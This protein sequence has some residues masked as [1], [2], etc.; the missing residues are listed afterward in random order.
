[1][2]SCFIT[3]QENIVDVYAIVNIDTS[4]VFYGNI[5]IRYLVSVKCIKAT[6]SLKLFCRFR[7]NIHQSVLKPKC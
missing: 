2:D 5:I 7:S 6:F 1:M 3:S 4:F